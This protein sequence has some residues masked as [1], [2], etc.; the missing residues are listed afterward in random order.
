[1][2][3]IVGLGNPGRQYS[4]T[5]HNIGFIVIDYLAGKLGINVD[6]IKF[7]SLVGEGCL[8]MERVVLVKPQTYMNLSGEAVLDM[9]RWYKLEPSDM[10]VIYDDMD[11]PAGKLRLRIKGSAGGH[12]GM[13]SIIYLV[14]SDE[15]P[16]LR[17]GIGRPINEH[18][19][20]VDFVL[21]KFSEE[22]IKI[23]STAVEKAVEAVIAVIEHGGERAMNTINADNSIENE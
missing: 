5:R 13:K 22:E 21:G 6:K 7:K 4:L 23:M 1:M 8:G 15:I 18:M 2:K 17:V 19:E 12:N 11:L 10:L 20:S 16:R 14:G 3:L 9:V